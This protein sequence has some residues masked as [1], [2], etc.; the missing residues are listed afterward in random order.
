VLDF[1]NPQPARRQWSRTWRATKT[2]ASASRSFGSAST[3]E[4]RVDTLRHLGVTLLLGIRL[5]RRVGPRHRG[6]RHRPH[7]HRR[8]MQS[9]AQTHDTRSNDCG[10]SSPRHLCPG[11][12]ADMPGACLFGSDQYFERLPWL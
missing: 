12:W 4:R 1:V 2:S 10:E 8:G 9:R 7:R 3:W 5:R 11:S 6:R